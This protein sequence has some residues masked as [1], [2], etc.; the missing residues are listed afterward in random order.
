MNIEKLPK[1]R[2]SPNRGRS[3]ADNREANQLYASRK[4]AEMVTITHFQPA[5]KRNRMSVLLHRPLE[6]TPL[7]VIWPSVNVE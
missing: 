1:F 6:T 4:V 3:V 2:I 5:G 7:L